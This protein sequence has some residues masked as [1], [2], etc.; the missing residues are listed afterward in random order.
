MTTKWH[1]IS[2]TVFHYAGL[3]PDR[4]ALVDGHRTFSYQALARL[5]GQAA[6][7]LTNLG[8]KQGMPVG[9][10]MSNSAEHIVLSLA[11][12]RVGAVLTEL[13]TEMTDIEMAAR[14]SRF[15][16]VATF[17]DAGGPSS[18]AAVAVRV[19]RNWLEELGL[20]SGDARAVSPAE[21]LRMIVLSSG[22]TGIPKGIV[23]TQAQR[24][25]R[26]AAWS[27]LFHDRWS[28][29]DPGTLILPAPPSMSLFAQ[30]LVNQLLMGGTI[31]LLP[32][33]SMASDLVT[34]ISTWRDVIC[35]IVPGMARAFIESAKG[36]DLLFPNMRA[37]ISG[38][39]PLA[40]YE[41][42]DL[43]KRVTPNIYEVYGS[44]GFGAVCHLRPVDIQ[45]HGN[46]VGRPI[47]APGNEIELVGT[48]DKP[49]GPGIEGRLRCRGPNMSVGF[50]NPEDN[51]RGA[52]HFADGWYYPG[53]VL[54]RDEAG[55]FYMRGREDDAFVAGELTVY[56][57][58]IEDV[59]MR[60]PDIAEAVIVGRPNKAGGID[61][62]GFIVGRNGL[63][64]ETVVAHCVATLPAAKRPRM[65][66]YLDAMP[67]TGNG[68]LDRPALKEAAIR[69][70]EKPA[71]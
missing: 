25:A 59:I 4:L 50:Y 32:K 65:I 27:A 47:S 39:L 14:V 55:Y 11:A 21:E 26:V 54:Q 58:E 60:H 15:G 12:L 35:P 7:Y 22:S 66:F 23:T 53:D 24:M 2:D 64:H 62:A 8:L 3:H 29:A 28:S 18:P 19:P 5:V 51:A 67:R 1:N 61:L 6:V 46:S 43:M 45:D 30:F 34:A 56:P 10:A 42:L 71:G 37:M 57:T 48:D 33:F 52:E 36:K 69:L 44:G 49:V 41:K 31:V 63:Q 40:G 68:K 9:V 17:V 38:G 13:P 70:G 20:L 16:I